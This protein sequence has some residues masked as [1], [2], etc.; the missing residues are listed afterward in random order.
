MLPEFTFPSL[1]YEFC[2]AQVSLVGTLMFQTRYF[3][4]ENIPRRGGVMI[5]CNHQS[6]LDPPLVGAGC[7]RAMYFMARKTLFT[8]PLFGRLIHSVHAVPIDREGAG[9]SGIKECL[10]LLK[11]GEA[12]LI[13]PEGTRT[14]DGEVQP[15]RPGFTTLAARTGA[16][17]VPAAIEG[18]FHAWPR[19]RPLP[20]PRHVY[21]RYGKPITA[22]EIGAQDER[23]LGAI[24]EQRVRD[25]QAELRQ[26]PDVTVGGWR[27]KRGG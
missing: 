9:I 7:P 14:L 16:V 19:W 21:V 17:I 25:C 4:R 24:V 26:H 12:L 13:F 23:A 18:A 1:W 3:G 15:F 27:V 5:C 11:R 20:V 8:N 22:A 6:H 10:K 2:K